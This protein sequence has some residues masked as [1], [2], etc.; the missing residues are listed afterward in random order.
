M[1]RFSDLLEESDKYPHFRKVD[2]MD[3]SA[4]IGLLY[5]RAAFRLNLQETLEIWNHESAQDIFATTMSY[6]RVQFIQRFITFN[7]KSTR[8]DRWKS[9]KF[10]CLRELFE[11]MN[12][13]NSKRCFPS[14]LLTVDKTLYP[15]H[16]S[17][18]FKQYNP[19]K[20]A[21]YGLLYRSLCD[22]PVSY[23]Y[24][25]MLV[26]YIDKKKSGKKN[27]I[28]LTTMH[29]K[30]KV[31]NDQ[32]SK[33]QVLGMYN[34]TKGGV[35]VVDLISC[36][37]STR[38]KSKRW[39]LTGFAFMLDTIRT[40]SKTILQDNKKEYRNFEF[41]YQLGKALV[42]PKIQHRLEN[43][44]GLQIQILQKM[45]RV[46]GLPEVNV[47]PITNPGIAASGRCQKCVE[48]IVGK[49][50]YKQDREKLNNKLKTKCHVW[51][52]FLCKKHQYICMR[53]FV[54]IVLNR[55]FVILS[56]VF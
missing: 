52:C 26:S 48:A 19:S 33:P 56:L 36:H 18:G 25:I 6:N 2:K 8:G 53:L 41:T 7:D 50:N 35:D 45:R 54:K 3:L 39:P 15:Y 23:T 4:F 37:H 44:N 20:P 12:E 32:R 9:D 14:P 49:K 11:M 24:Y 51:S 1:E 17:I 40:N 46:L 42:M 47:R 34:H 5:L 21:K 30:I 10:A 31:T 13:Q 16:G 28:S 55:D 27:I 29:D 22:S 43:S 38:M